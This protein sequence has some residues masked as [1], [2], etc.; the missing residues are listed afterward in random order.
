[1]TLMFILPIFVHINTFQTV[2]IYCSNL[3]KEIIKVLFYSTKTQLKTNKG[4]ILSFKNSTLQCYSI[5]SVSGGNVFIFVNAYSKNFILKKIS[6]PI[7][8]K[9]TKKKHNFLF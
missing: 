9:K 4:K 6:N 3:L 1:M 2:L 7:K 5:P 8:L